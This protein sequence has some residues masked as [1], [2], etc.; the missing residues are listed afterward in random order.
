MKRL[1]K[2]IL[3]FIMGLTFTFLVNEK[4]YSQV[5]AAVHELGKFAETGTVEEVFFNPQH[6]YTKA[7]LSARPTF[8][9]SSKQRRIILEGDV[10]SPI[11]PPSGCPFHPRCQEKGKHIACGI[12]E[13]G[14]IYLGGDHYIYCLPFKDERDSYEGIEY[15]S[16]TWK[17]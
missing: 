13:P 6:P 3:I 1:N 8:D 7:L 4:S 9:P 11:N 14:K 15:I 5:A 17:T 16:D 12:E 2:V 10:P